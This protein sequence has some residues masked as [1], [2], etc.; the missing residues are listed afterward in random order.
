[1]QQV[2]LRYKIRH[3]IRL[4]ISTE[5]IRITLNQKPEKKLSISIPHIC[6]DFICFSSATNA[7]QNF[8][9]WIFLNCFVCLHT[10]QKENETMKI[11]CGGCVVIITQHLFLNHNAN[12]H[13]RARKIE[14]N[15]LIEKSKRTK[16]ICFV[17]IHLTV[18]QMD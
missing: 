6:S 13:E 15:I 4:I 18:L 11:H 5:P 16:E 7:R 12:G 14:R 8:M 17:V 1:M 10:L 2:V 9:T 3:N